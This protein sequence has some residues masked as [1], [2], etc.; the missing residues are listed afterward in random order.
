MRGFLGPFEMVFN[1]L[2][3][4]CAGIQYRI[5]KNQGRVSDGLFLVKFLFDLYWVKMIRVATLFEEVQS[6]HG[7][8]S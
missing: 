6:L 1:K 3:I 8:K 2:I 4:G 7:C 5:G